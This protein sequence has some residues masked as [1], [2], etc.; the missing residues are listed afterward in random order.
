MRIFTLD[1]S[2]RSTGWAFYA[3]GDER[4]FNGVWDRIASEY[5]TRGGIYYALYALLL[6]AHS[7]FKFDA[8]YAEEPIN[9]IPN[10]VATQAE[11]I[12]ISVGMGA[13]VELFCHT[14]NVKLRWVHQARWRREFLGRMP[15]AT[16]S[17]DLK[18]MALA[19]C[20]QLGLKPNKHDDAEALGV[21][22]YACQ[23][24]RV[25]MPW[26]GALPVAGAGQ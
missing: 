20:R 18:D 25:F 17:A 7:T 2:K 1:P 12:W 10:A 5:S 23:V 21:L 22:T 8:I 9:L 19:R 15:R 3:S 24:E 4:P 11:N 16:R 13:T 26:L 14:M 6:D